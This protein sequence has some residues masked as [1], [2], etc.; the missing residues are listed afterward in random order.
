M[1]S[2]YNYVRDNYCGQITDDSYRFD[3]ELV[4]RVISR[5]KRGKAAGPDNITSE[6]DGYWSCS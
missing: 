1:R 2:A 4:E 3:A 6:D 5:M